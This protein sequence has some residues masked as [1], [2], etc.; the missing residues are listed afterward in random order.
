MLNRYIYTLAR[1][2]TFNVQLRYKKKLDQYSMDKIVAEFKQN[3]ELAKQFQWKVT[4]LQ[5]IKELKEYFIEKDKK[6]NAPKVQQ[7]WLAWLFGWK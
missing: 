2:I 6:K 1:E 7:G 5:V 3:Q 4:Y